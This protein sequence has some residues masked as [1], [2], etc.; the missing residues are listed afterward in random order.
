[1]AN[2]EAKLD[3]F[4]SFLGERPW[5]AGDNI[6]HPDFHMYEMLASHKK[7]SPETVEVIGMRPGEFIERK[8]VIIF[9]ISEISQI[10]GI[11][12]EI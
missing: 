7:L 9:S 10:G 6:T 8:L 2:V 4:S 5:F 3:Q 11:H 12:E 1:M